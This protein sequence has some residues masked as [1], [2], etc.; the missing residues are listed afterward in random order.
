MSI[1][2]DRIKQLRK[3]KNITLKEL[4]EHLGIKEATM[5]RYESGNIKSIPYDNIVLIAEYLGC[6]PQYLMGWSDEVQ[7]VT[8]L[9]KCE[10]KLVQAYREHPEMQDAVNKL[11]G[12][13]FDEA[14]ADDMI[15]CCNKAKKIKEPT[16]A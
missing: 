3:Q 7:P 2:N 10:I 9:S 6:Q 4:A 5:Q 11:L 16:K 1:I 8:N 12:I 15:A 13:T 14:V